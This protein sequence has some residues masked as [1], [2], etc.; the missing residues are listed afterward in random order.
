MNPKPTLETGTMGE[1][2]ASAVQRFPD[3]V[4][5]VEPDGSTI[6]YRELGERIGRLIRLLAQ[7]GLRRGDT[8]VQLSANRPETFAVIAAVYVAGLR[9]VAL[10]TMGSE[11]DHA[12]VIED[13]EAKAVIVDPAYAARG[14]A[15]RARSPRVAHWLAHGAIEDMEDLWALAAGCAPEAL[16]PVGEAEDIVR[17]AYTGGTTGRSKGVMLSNRALCT[18]TV[19]ALAGIDWPDE[20]AYLCPAPISHGAG[21][22][23]VPTLMRGGRVILQRGFDAQRFLEAVQAHRPT[24]TWLV[25]TMIYA[26]LDHPETRAT[27]WR[28][29]HSLVYS[30]APMAPARIREA[31][32][33]FGPCLIQCFGQ[34]ESPNTILTLSRAD[35]AA[36]GER[37][38]SAG[39][40]FPLIRVALLD[41]DCREVPDGEIGEICVRGPLLMS[42]YWK[43]PELTAE[44][45][46]GDWLHTGDLAR[47]D[48]DGYVYVVDRKKDM[49]ISGGFNVYPKEIED[50]LAA[51]PAVAAAA[52]IGVPDERWG[53]AVK[54]VVAL[55]PGALVDAEAL[56]ARVREAKG[57]VYAP[58]S[59][60]FEAQLPLTPL[61]KVDKKALRARWWQSG[62]RAVN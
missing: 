30:A 28:C 48:A 16:K 9:S 29:L 49:I 52:V 55:K 31:L 51:H 56:I 3:R 2:I 43:Q 37:L 58:K 14:R 8:V 40:P 11:D 61:G 27:D 32:G 26:L 25:P 5:F 42:G 33:V 22:L 59:V 7:L 35:H 39:R 54:A 23:V 57:P 1:L 60:D 45:F 15:L 41:D 21:S 53:E 46:R 6:G 20:V 38:A 36:G 34:T 50:V 62:G 12:F 4:A 18:N 19:L 47:R 24:L 17:L 10:H 13:S 44:A